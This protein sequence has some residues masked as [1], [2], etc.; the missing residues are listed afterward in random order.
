MLSTLK[1]TRVIHKFPR[2]F[3]GLPCNGNFLKQTCG[4]QARWH[5]NTI[6]TVTANLCSTSKMLMQYW[7]TC[8][9]P[10]S[11]HHLWLLTSHCGQMAPGTRIPLV[12]ENSTEGH[13]LRSQQPATVFIMVT[14]LTGDSGD[15]FHRTNLSSLAGRVTDDFKWFNWKQSLLH[16]LMRFGIQAASWVISG[17]FQ[18]GFMKLKKFCTKMIR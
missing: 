4:S 16:L 5:S 15:L 13:V 7:N 17:L 3:S 2:N 10:W 9:L 12:N 1:N 11:K 6:L 18:T 14:I 8:C